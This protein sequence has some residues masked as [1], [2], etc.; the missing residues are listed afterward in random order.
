MATVCSVCTFT[1]AALQAL[2]LLHVTTPVVSA[3]L[4]SVSVRPQIHTH[5]TSSFG[6]QAGPA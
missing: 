2:L 4:C 5:I 6:R 3:L 1:L